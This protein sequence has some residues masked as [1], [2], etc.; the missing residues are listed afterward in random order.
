MAPIDWSKTKI[1]K[2]VCKDLSII[3]CYVG[4]TINI[5]RRRCQHKTACNNVA[6]AD[7]ALKK[8]A[9]I[10][11]NGGWD[12]WEL[13]L[14]EDYLECTS[15]EMARQRERFWYETLGSELNR[16]RPFVSQDEYR[17]DASAYYESNK[18]RIK[19][20]ETAYREANKDKIKKDVAA[21][22]ESNKEQI[23]ERAAAYYES[24]K[25]KIKE[26]ETAH[27][28]SNKEQIKKRETAY[29]EANKDKL[30]KYQVEY[31]K[32]NKDKIKERMNA[33]H[34]SNRASML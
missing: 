34:K 2:I 17:K 18:E 10:R 19:E 27:R 31:R 15:G 9:F 8:Y 11:A 26:R 21:Y 1:Y 14:V 12:N 7:H 3:E 6:S 30:K 28:E 25:E 16:Y 4:S 22:R 29:Y 33:Y 20:R 32:F 24:N 5:I 23:K 13:I